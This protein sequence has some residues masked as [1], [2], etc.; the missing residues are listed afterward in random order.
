MLPLAKPLIRL[1]LAAFAVC[2]S[3]AG[4]EGMGSSESAASETG[5][6]NRPSTFVLEARTVE[7][8]AAIGVHL[9]RP[10]FS[11]ANSDV[12]LEG[13]GFEGEQRLGIIGGGLVY[14]TGAGSR[15]AWEVSAFFEGLRSTD[16]FAYPQIG[17][18]AGFSPDRW[19][20]LRANGY[21]PLQGKDSRRI[22]T[23]RSSRIE[24]S[25]TDRREVGF[26]RER[27]SERAPMRGFDVEAEFRL[28]NPP[29]WVDPRLAIGY[30]Y[31]EAKDRPEV[32]A[33][34]LVRGE[35]HFAKHWS[36]EGEWRDDAHGIDQEWRVGI[37][38]QMLFGGPAGADGGREGERYLPVKRFPWPTLARGTTKGKT[39][40]GDSRTLSP[41]VPGGCCD[42]GEDPLIY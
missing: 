1:V 26:S 34:P 14:R 37:K 42:S 11:T 24:G 29:R 39:Q 4:G 9:V 6:W 21:L 15:S 27:F 13:Y 32:Y 7:H 16:G 31:R 18:G 30:A 38:F 17:V 40:R 35:L 36:V 10:I 41:A 20:T 12:L 25:G 22:G 33:G 2:T 5:W 8:D 23:D 28:P 19:I 3:F